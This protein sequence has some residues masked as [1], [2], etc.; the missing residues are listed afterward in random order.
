[1]MWLCSSVA[2]VHT[3]ALMLIALF[4]VAWPMAR[5][6]SRTSPSPRQGLADKAGRTGSRPNPAEP[7]GLG[8]RGNPTAAGRFQ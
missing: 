6:R 4:P 7:P 8:R 1:M 2:S 5:P 3:P